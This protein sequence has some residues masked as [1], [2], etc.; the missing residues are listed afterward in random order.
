LFRAWR[1]GFRPAVRLFLRSSKQRWRSDMLERASILA[2][3]RTKTECCAL[4][5]CSVNFG[6]AHAIFETKINCVKA[7]APSADHT[8]CVGSRLAYYPAKEVASALSSFFPTLFQ[9]RRREEARRTKQ[10]TVSGELPNAPGRAPPRC[11]VCN[12]A[13]HHT[14]KCCGAPL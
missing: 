13:G 2:K 5:D 10:Q 1:H 14:P 4:L 8:A 6:C 9:K 12:G 7:T 11:S 3:V